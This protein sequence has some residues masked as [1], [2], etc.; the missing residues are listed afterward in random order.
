MRSFASILAVI[1]SVGLGHLGC[2]APTDADAD[3]DEAAL[4][5]ATQA[6]Y[7]IPDIN[8]GVMERKPNCVYRTA[9]SLY[10]R[11][12]NDEVFDP[13]AYRLAKVR[14]SD[15]EQ[16]VVVENVGGSSIT[17]WVGQGLAVGRHVKIRPGESA[18]LQS[19]DDIWPEWDVLARADDGDLQV[20]LTAQ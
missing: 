13:G 9:T 8:G 11:S 20:V 1:V 3:R 10:C 4:G 5:Q 7:V 6:L 19:I 16:R 12:R 17:A 18:T 14:R 15:G 2:A